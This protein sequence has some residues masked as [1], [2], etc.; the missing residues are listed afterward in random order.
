MY[1]GNFECA[2]RF[3]STFKYARLDFTSISKSS[4]IR[5]ARLGLAFS[6]VLGHG[7]AGKVLSAVSN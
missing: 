7:N 6:K 4:S 1:F 3:K 2:L 5:K